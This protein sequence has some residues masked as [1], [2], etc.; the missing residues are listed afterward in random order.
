M[1]LQRTLAYINFLENFNQTCHSSYPYCYSDPNLSLNLRYNDLCYRDLF[2]YG[3]MWSYQIYVP[4]TWVILGTHTQHGHSHKKLSHFLSYWSRQQSRKCQDIWSHVHRY[5]CCKF[6]VIFLWHPVSPSPS[7]SCVFV[8][9]RVCGRAVLPAELPGRWAAELPVPKP[10]PFQSRRCDGD[11]LHPANQEAPH[12]FTERQCPST[13]AAF[14]AHS[15]A[16][17]RLAGAQ[18]HPHPASQHQVRSG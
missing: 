3:Y 16:P 18:H 9:P 14:D 13:H 7:L 6:H 10:L 12:P 17:T 11:V 2:F 5:K 15:H 1:G 8:E 4:M